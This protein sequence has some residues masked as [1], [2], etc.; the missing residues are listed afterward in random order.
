MIRFKPRNVGC[1]RYTDVDNDYC[2]VMYFDHIDFIDEK[3]LG[4]FLKA[5]FRDPDTE[6]KILDGKVVFGLL[7]GFCEIIK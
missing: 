4:K 2:D 1:W 5:Y 6:M 7:I 3:T